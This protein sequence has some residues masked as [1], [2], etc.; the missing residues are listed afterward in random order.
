[1][2]NKKKKSDPLDLAYDDY[3]DHI[4]TS[5]YGNDNEYD[6]YDVIADEYA[7]KKLLFSEQDPNEDYLDSILNEYG[8]R[9]SPALNRETPEPARKK[10]DP[11][12]EEM[13]K[14][15]DKAAP[16]PPKPA[17]EPR[18]RTF[19]ERPYEQPVGDHTTKLDVP[20]GVLEVIDLLKA[21]TY[22]SYLVGDCVNML[23][24]G[25]RVMDFDIACNATIER[26]VAICEDRFKVRQ[27]LLERGELIIIN[28][29]MGISVA[30][31][32]S[33]IDGSGKPIYCKTVDEDLHRRTFT[34]ETVAYNPD[35]GIYDKFGGLACITA[36]KTILRAIDEE[37][38]EAMELEQA[39]MKKKPKDAPQKIVI[40]AIRENPEC[41][42]IAMQKFARGEA[43]I[44]P[45]TLRN[46]NENAELIDMM[47]PTEISRYFRRI[48]L[49][50]RIGEAI[51]DFREVIFHIFPVLRAQLDFE[52]KSDYQEYTLFEHTAKAVGYGFPDYAV[53]LALLLHG[54][55]KPD[56]A[57]DRGEYMTYY[58]HSERGVML[59]RDAFDE[60]DADDSVVDRVL[61]MIAHHD[62]HI[63][64][65]NIT[66]FIS[67]F[68]TENTRLLLLFQSANVR[69]KNSD[70]LNDRVSA[71]LR[72]LA[73]NISSYAPPPPRAAQ[74][75]RG[76]F[77]R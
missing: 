58:G 16:E 26:I 51:M 32:R 60:Y 71:S 61:F 29:G 25:E 15:E 70:P 46:I 1:M 45:Y 65:E 28:G 33:R 5:L 68:G 21:H 43:E 52:Q 49:G 30:P 72:Q 56:C 67:A 23:V 17:P 14:P 20:K 57:A 18:E 27:D 64:P 54:I 48:I 12:P 74:G 59:A 10:P 11:E 76:R 42:L 53:R 35:S 55:G 63:S 36:E 69:A 8:G 22:T 6:E 4:D 62:D 7:S 13:P 39:S 24:L 41:I 75:L 3:E 34:S 66:E 77:P 19:K 9:R 37:K 40:E 2:E 73:D 38:F 31:Y 50:R 47:L 44:S